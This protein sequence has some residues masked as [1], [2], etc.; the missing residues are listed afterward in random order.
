M[1]FV[2]FEGCLFKRLEWYVFFHNLLIP[3]RYSLIGM[4]VLMLGKL[5]LLNIYGFAW[6]LIK[7]FLVVINF[8]LGR[9]D[10]LFLVGISLAFKLFSIRG[11]C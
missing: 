3:I 5:H 6:L 2:F 7:S 9:I 10:W 8:A 11:R 4:E 1:F